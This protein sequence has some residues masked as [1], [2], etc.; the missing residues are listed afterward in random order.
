MLSREQ[1]IEG[2]YRGDFKASRATVG[3]TAAKLVTTAMAGRKQ[4]FIQNL[5][6]TTIY[7]DDTS[8]NLTTTSGYPI[9]VGC[10]MLLMADAAKDIYAISSASTK[11]V[12]VMEVA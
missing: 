6:D 3:V 11:S 1:M 2:G 5:S 7:I 10:E 9:Q 8:T 12:A 4:L